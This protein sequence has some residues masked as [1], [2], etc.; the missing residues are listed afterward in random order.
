MLWLQTFNFGTEPKNAA[1]PAQKF[2]IL[3]PKG[4]EY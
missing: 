4:S 1:Q 2:S 3:Y